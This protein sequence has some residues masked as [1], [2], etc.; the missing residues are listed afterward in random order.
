VIVSLIA[1]T[2]TQRGLKIKAEL[3]DGRYPTGT[4]VTDA[5]LA[6]IN[7]RPNAFHGDWNYVVLPNRKT[8]I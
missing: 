5:E 6:Q 1:N 4:K 3:D 2:T 7:L 8:T